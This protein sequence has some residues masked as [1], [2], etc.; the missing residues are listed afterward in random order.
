M[1]RPRSLFPQTQIII[2]P[3]PA[4]S[5]VFLV[6]VALPSW[7]SPR[8]ETVVPPLPSSCVPHSPGY[9][10]LLISAGSVEITVSLAVSL[11]CLR[12]W[13][14]VYELDFQVVT[15][16]P[17]SGNTGSMRLSMAS[18]YILFGLQDIFKQLNFQYPW[19]ELVHSSSWPS[20]P[21]CF[22]WP[23]LRRYFLCLTPEGHW[24][25]NPIS[26]YALQSD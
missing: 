21:R 1:N 4:P 23:S 7:Q 24:V 10:I 17:R 16:L 9:Q 19:A 15:Q 3:R 12:P 18:G 14:L 5:S 2:P 22:M 26:F 25:C 11:L 13:L 20:T 8:H 6:L